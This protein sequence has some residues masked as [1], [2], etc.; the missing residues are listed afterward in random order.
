MVIQKAVIPVAG[1]GIRLNPITKV[2]PKE[3][4]PVLNKPL[5][6]YILEEL[7]EA[8]VNQIGIV[9]SSR[10]PLIKEYLTSSSQP[11]TLLSKHRNID[12]QFISQEVPNGLGNAILEAKEFVDDSPFIVCLPDDLVFHHISAVKQ[13]QNKYRSL[14]HSLVGV[15]TVPIHK[16]SHYGIVKPLNQP[17]EVSFKADYFVEKPI[18]ENAPSNLAVIGR[19]LF[20]KKLMDLLGKYSGLVPNDDLLT[21]AKNALAQENSVSAV[22]IAGTR[23]DAGSALGITQAAIHELCQQPEEWEQLNTFLSSL[24]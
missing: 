8:G 13:L 5:I 10:K 21:K 15:V 22:H 1:Q 7:I 14:Q 3:L 16:V 11:H 12:L 19:Y 24:S 4:L 20:T 9:T 17:D 2:V 18:P 23:I 6:D